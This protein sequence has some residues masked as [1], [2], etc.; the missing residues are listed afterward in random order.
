MKWWMILF[1]LLS[2]AVNTGCLAVK[3]NGFQ[4]IAEKHPVGMEEVTATPEGTALIRDLGRYI[5]DLEH[6]LEKGD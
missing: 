1:L 4:E 3:L 5:A 2:L 6:R